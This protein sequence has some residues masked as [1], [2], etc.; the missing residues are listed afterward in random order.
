M[1][2]ADDRFGRGDATGRSPAIKNRSGRVGPDSEARRGPRGSRAYA[3]RPLY[4]QPRA[5]APKG[6]FGRVDSEPEGEGRKYGPIPR[7][8]A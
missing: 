8:L 4:P 6:E 7:G 1:M 5:T 3:G 2:L